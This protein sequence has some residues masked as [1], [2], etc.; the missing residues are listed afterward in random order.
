[1]ARPRRRPHGSPPLAVLGDLREV[2]EVTEPA[3]PDTDPIAAALDAPR[4]APQFA[5]EGD[6]GPE[7]GGGRYERPPFP[8]G[9]PVRPLGMSADIAG[10]QKCY[11]LDVNGQL[12]G[13]EAGN[14]HGK[15]SL[16]ALFGAR[17]DWLEAQFPQWSKPVTEYDRKTQ[18]STVIKPSEIIGFDQAEASRALIEEC[19]RRGIFDPA[20]RMRGRG[21]H[22]LPQGGL[23]VHYGDALLAAK[24]HADGSI[25]EFNWHECG[26]H[27]G[28]VYPAAEATPRPSHEGV[29]SKPAEKLLRLLTTWQ[30]KRQLIDARFLM[31]WIGAAMV[32]GALKW[33]PNIWITGGA[34]TGK[35]TINGEEGVLDEIFGKGVFRTGSASAAAIRQSLKNSTV[36]VMFDEIE[37]SAD[38]RHVTAVVELARV[39]SSGAT[40]HRGG[41]DHQAHEFTLRSCFQFSS[42]NIPPLQPQDRSRLGILELN[43]FA[44][45][46]V[47]PVLREWNL[48]EIGKQL[49]RRMIDGWYRF[50]DTLHAFQEALAARGHNRRACD[51]FGTLLACADLLLNDERAQDDEIAEWAMMCSPERMAEISEATPD[52]EACLVHML[53]HQVQARGGDEREALGSWIGRAVGLAL[54][55]LL[56][57]GAEGVSA[58]Q[59]VRAMTRLQ[60]MGLKLVNANWHPPQHDAKGDEIKAGRWGSEQYLSGSPGF[61][62]VANSHQGLA[63]VFN[64]TTWQGGVWR[65][66]LARTPGAIASELKF[67][68]IKARA[69]LLPLHVV[70]DES[71]LPNA[72]RPDAHAEWMMAQMKGAEA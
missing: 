35:S 38:N 15:N 10:S 56:G 23:V 54:A 24:Q 63:G 7:L 59:A 48:P 58:D 45:N 31:G 20:G 9:C 60:E 43:P 65:Q 61:L 25:R 71:E 13:L 16:I 2:P 47:P 37:A 34:G 11:Y 57:D 46:A 55:P 8:A 18:T 62:A 33:R 27:G 4:P 14:R 64:G 49:Q 70:L 26:L 66:S 72:S 52:H 5:R 6:E 67:G 28:Y 19:V 36:P 1:M 40:I 39:S 50:E 53:T 44:K 32:G 12:V 68:R 22:A 41:A 29:S 51:Q 69:V 17:S 30:W 3:T 21:A 42:I